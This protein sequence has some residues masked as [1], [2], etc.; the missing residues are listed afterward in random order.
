MTAHRSYSRDA[1]GASDRGRLY[2]LWIDRQV[3]ANLLPAGARLNHFA[4]EPALSKKLKDLGIFD[5]TAT[6]LQMDEVDNE[7]DIMNMPFGDE[8]FDYF[9]CSHV[10]EHVE[11]DDRAIE[12]LFRITRSGGSGILMAPVMPSLDHTLEDPTIKDEAGRWRL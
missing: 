10:L 9:P 1:C 6:D 5:Y 2:A 4:P 3:E 8:S 12:E 7:V 11:D